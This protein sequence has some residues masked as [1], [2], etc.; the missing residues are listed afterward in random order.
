MFCILDTETVPNLLSQTINTVGGQ[1]N[2]R[3][4]KWNGKF[5]YSKSVTDQNLSNL[6]ASAMYDINDENQISFRYQNMNKLP[7]NNYN[8]YQSSYKDT[9]GQ[10][11]F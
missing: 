4:D 3:K 7:N 2:Y 6:D 8:L 11:I 1:Y 9:I 10:T 5:L